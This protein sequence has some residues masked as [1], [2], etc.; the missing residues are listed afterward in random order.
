MQF[1]LEQLENVLNS[2][3]AWEPLVN[4]ALI[5][6]TDH[7]ARRD[8]DKFGGRR[9]YRI[10]AMAFKAFDV[11]VAATSKRYKYLETKKMRLCMI[12]NVQVPVAMKFYDSLYSLAKRKDIRDIKGA[13]DTEVVV[14]NWCVAMNGAKFGGDTLKVAR[15]GS[16]R[17]DEMLGLKKIENSFFAL[18]DALVDDFVHACSDRGRELTVQYLVRSHMILNRRE[19]VKGREIREDDDLLFSGAEDDLR[20]LRKLLEHQESQIDDNNESP[21]PDLV[22]SLS[23]YGCIVAAVAAHAN[24]EN[25]DV[26]L[27]RLAQA[28]HKPFADRIL[29]APAIQRLGRRQ[30]SID[31]AYIIDVFMGRGGEDTLILAELKKIMQ[32]ETAKIENVRDALFALVDDGNIDERCLEE[33]YSILEAN[34]LVFGALDIEV[35]LAVLRK[36]KVD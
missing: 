10:P 25:A 12:N 1:A 18:F 21:S 26:V 11:L 27:S 9:K 17:E 33:L 19:P 6:D 5:E 24:E 22:N 2:E 8:G 29:D 31:M 3:S 13:R 28:I 30:F 36:V 14:R 23:F 16:G 7:A 15:E 35:V 4:L 20:H 34:G 32:M